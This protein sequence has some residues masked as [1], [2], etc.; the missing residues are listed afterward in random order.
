[1]RTY[2]HP[3]YLYAFQG[4]IVSMIKDKLKYHL[5]LFLIVSLLFSCGKEL[6]ETVSDAILSANQLLSKS[7][8][9]EAINILEAV[10]RQNGNKSYL[11]TLA[12]G[13]ACRGNYSE[14]ITLKVL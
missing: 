8:C 5:Y 4:I 14:I 2:F 12:S 6:D 10:G 1:M 11:I 7:K 3:Y 9:Q 13:Y